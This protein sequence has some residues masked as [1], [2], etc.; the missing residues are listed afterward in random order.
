VIDLD[1]VMP[2]HFISDVGDMLRTYISPANEEEKD[3]TKIEVRADYL[4]AIWDGYMS[5]MKDELSVEE[6]NYFV[7]AGKFVIYMQAIRFLTDYLNDD[8]YYGTKYP[9]HNL[10]RAKNQITLLKKIIEKDSDLQQIIK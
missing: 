3:C 6:Q 4:K 8:V 2:G 9:G 7:Y 1:T 5:E 10:V